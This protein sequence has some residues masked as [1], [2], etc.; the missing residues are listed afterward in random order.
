MVPRLMT[1]IGTVLA[2]AVS[3]GAI[4]AVYPPQIADDK[5]TQQDQAGPYTIT[6][7]DYATGAYRDKN[8][9]IRGFLWDHWSQRRRARLTVTRFSKEGVATNATYLVEPDTDGTWNIR[10]ILDRP[11]LKGTVDGH[12]EQT[13][14]S[15]KRVEPLH[16]GESRRAFIPDDQTVSADAYRLVFYDKRGKE[17]KGI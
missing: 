2:F 16:E 13:I 10:V 3:V 9:E 7:K 12:S 8:T 1:L 11:A 17:I 5:V 6:N 4:G 15:V 14:S